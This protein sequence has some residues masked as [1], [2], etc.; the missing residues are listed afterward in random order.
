MISL[1]FAPLSARGFHSWQGI[2]L[3]DISGLKLT[4]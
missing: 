4:N 3:A 2:S 1:F